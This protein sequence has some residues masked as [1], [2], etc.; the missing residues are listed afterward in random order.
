ML[1]DASTG[2]HNLSLQDYPPPVS[3]TDCLFSSQTSSH[4]PQASPQVTASRFQRY[5]PYKT[6]R[7]L[8]SDQAQLSRLISRAT[9]AIDRGSPV[10]RSK[11]TTRPLRHRGLTDPFAHDTQFSAFSNDATAFR[12]YVNEKEAL[13]TLQF[14]R[15]P[16]QAMPTNVP[17]AKQNLPFIHNGPKPFS[18]YRPKKQ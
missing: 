8:G 11:P 3:K 1:E 6:P 18:M 15:P 7:R 12:S 9:K 14:P 13:T 2:N 4:T 10:K 16:L 5:S 17:L